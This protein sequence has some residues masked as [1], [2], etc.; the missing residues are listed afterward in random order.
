MF[1]RMTSLLLTVLLCLFLLPTASFAEQSTWTKPG[2]SDI[3]ILN[4]GVMLVDGGNFYFAENGIFV[5]NGEK[6]RQ[7]SADKGKNLNLYDGYIYYTV[8]PEIRRVPTDGGNA[9][10]VFTASAEIGQMYVIGGALKF[11]AGG[12]AYERP[13]QGGP[14]DTISDLQNV[15]D[16]IPTQYGDIMLTGEVLDY[17][18]QINGQPVLSNV[19]SC[20]TDSGYL[21]V[22]IHNQ[23]YMVV[24]KKLFNGFNSGSDLL[25]FNIHGTVALGQLLKPD[26]KN[27]AS[28]YD[29]NNELQPN[30]QALSQDAGETSNINLM[31]EETADVS[32]PISSPVPTVSDG[33]KNIVKRA[34]QLT[35]IKWTPLEDIY[36]WGQTGVFK[37]ETTYTGIPYGQP[38]NCN[39]Y[40][41]Y[42]V[43]LET[44][45]TAALDNTSKLYTTYSSYNKTA[46]SMSTDC[47][48]FV[49]YAWGL[50]NRLTTYSMTGVAEIVS[51]QSIYSLQIGD[52]I[53]KTSSHIVLVSGLTYDGTGNIIGI[54]IMEETPVITRVTQ[55]GNGASKSLSNFQ[56]N[57]L[58]NGFVIYRNPNRDSVTYTPNPAVPLD[59]ETV[60]GMKTAAPKSHTTL[61]SGGKSVTLTSDTPE[62]SIY[63]TLDGTAPSVSGTRYT[64]AI[65]FTATAKLRA[66]AVSGSLT[67]NAI[68]EYTVKIPQAPTPTASVSNGL[69]SG[70]IVSSGSQI[71]LTSVSGATLYYTTDGT[72][73]TSASKVY[74]SPF[75]ITN[76]T[77]IK[78]IAEVKGMSCSQTA[79]AAYQ[80]GAVYT[81]SASAEIG[82]SI[83]P[84]GNSSVLT[85]GAK[86]YNITCSDSYAISDVL[87]DGVS[88]GAVASYTF[89]NIAANHNIAVSFKSTAQLPFTDTDSGAWYYKAVQF[90][91][92]KSLFNGTSGTTF[93][94]E[95]TMTRGMFVTVLGRYSG[96]SD[97]LT[98]GIGLVTGTGVNIRSGPSTDTKIVGTVSKKNTVVQVLTKSGNWYNVTYGSFTGY[99]RNDLICVYNGNYT[100]LVSNQYYS[101][102]VEWACIAGIANNIASTTFS[103]ESNIT[104]E[105]M[106]LM[107]YN[108]ASAYGKTLPLLSQKA[109]FTD[110][111]T[112]SESARTAVYALQEAEVINGMGDGTF[113]P[114]GTATRAQVAQIYMKFINTISQS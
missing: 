26:D 96:I 5:R 18:I 38:I 19:T 49:S 25:N 68:L 21:A 39:G 1:R 46:P 22:S 50:V 37:A 23:N 106:C 4:G 105:N 53:D 79:E 111:S 74:S 70:N 63:Y 10:C 114:Q 16:L 99:I 33:Q 82:G 85:S 92:A 59:G 97:G 112:I 78:A 94:P 8:G 32:A 54:E 45:A 100:D 60:D 64:G 90:A 81:I 80:I 24:L 71:K 58:N 84:S 57:Y 88:V 13:K 20:Y 104:R 87:V 98:S 101:P 30:Y 72:E 91:Y 6:I 107:L 93:S 14:V 11:L 7:L 27:I 89:S 77:T 51:D 2:N 76:D 56:S 75:T 73:P 36:Q 66:I 15:K 103:A 109:V 17:T 83:S 69:F 3:N 110:D 12:L 86:T 55:Y 65:T 43:S 108:Y 113:S 48:A 44:F 9:E 29:P 67:E 102:Y 47:S 40:I 35:E 95:M 62:S 61:I 28:E 31:A 34:R 41:G 52:C 42:G